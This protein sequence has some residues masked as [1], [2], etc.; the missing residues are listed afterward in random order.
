MNKLNKSKL[1][2]ITVSLSWV[3]MII[4]G[5]FFLMLAGNIVSK[6]QNNEELKTKIEIENTLRNVF[7]QY[8]RTS[9]IEENSLAPLKYIFKNTKVELLCAEGIPVL[10]MNDD[11]D[12]NNNYISTYPTFMTYIEHGRVDKAYMAVESFRMPFK[13]TNTLALLSNRNLVVID[14]NS[15]F[16]EKLFQKFKKTA[17]SELNYEYIDFSDLSTFADTYVKDKNL[18]SIVFVTDESESFSLTLANLNPDAYL[19]KIDEQTSQYGTIHYQDKEPKDY[20]FNYYDYDESL[21]LQT[22]AVFSNPLTF[23]CSYNLLFNSL[24]KVYDFYINKTQY[25]IKQD[26]TICNPSITKSGRN[27]YYE[28][29]LNTL[30]EIKEDI[31][32]NKFDNLVAIQT[33][34]DLFET[35]YSLLEEHTCPYIY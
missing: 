3:F 5:T 28:E 27:Y 34:L 24:D 29:M 30:L 22:M 11:V 14:S 16:G 15:N 13:I 1:A 2:A 7:N 12:T 31:A 32:L 18:N 6:Y 21:T 25:Y 20:F 9:G 35:Y 19:V 26:Y 10:S 8:A 4:I 23:N 17:Y 33:N